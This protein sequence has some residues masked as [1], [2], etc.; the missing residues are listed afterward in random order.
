MS[1]EL[2][3]NPTARLYVNPFKN[4][5]HLFWH[6]HSPLCISILS[7][8]VLTVSFMQS[9]SV[10]F[11]SFSKMLIKILRRAGLSPGPYHGTRWQVKRSYSKH[12]T[13]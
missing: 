2:L 8:N 11:L 10:C 9:L 12:L 6:T 4:S 13:V 1:Y 7:A 3:F 5:S